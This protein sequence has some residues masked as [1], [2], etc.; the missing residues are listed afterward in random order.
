MLVYCFLV[1]FVFQKLMIDSVDAF[2]GR[3]KDFIIL[4]YVR[5]G[6][7]QYTGLGFLRDQRRVNVA[8]TRA[9]KGV[10][11]VGNLALLCKDKVSFNSYRYSELVS[12]NKIAI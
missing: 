2:Q 7:Q 1:R 3:E 5:S 6:H 4:S 8:L 12:M 10:V 9:K 11:I